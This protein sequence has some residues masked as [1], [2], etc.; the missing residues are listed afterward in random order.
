MIG[1]IGRKGKIAWRDT[2]ITRMKHRDAK[3]E[4]ALEGEKEMQGNVENWG[5][6]GERQKL[7][8]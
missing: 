4:R 2:A 6:I 7:K 3:I 5:I 8:K 1:K